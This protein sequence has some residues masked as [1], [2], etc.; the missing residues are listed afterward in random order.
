MSYKFNSYVD[1]DDLNQSKKELEY[2]DSIGYGSLNFDAQYKWAVVLNTIEELGLNNQ[3]CKCIEIGGSISPIPLIL[4]NKHKVIDVDLQHNL[5]WFPL[6][7]GKKFLK[8]SSIKYNENNITYIASDDKVMTKTLIA[9]HRYGRYVDTVK[10]VKHINK[11]NPYLSYLKLLDSN[12]IDFICDTSSRLHLIDKGEQIIKELYRV[13]KPGGYVIKVSDVAHPDSTDYD[14]IWHCDKIVNLYKGYGF[15]VW[16]GE[17][18]NVEPFY[19]DVKNFHHPMDHF[20]RG[21]QIKFKNTST[22][23]E[24]VCSKLPKAHLLCEYGD[25]DRGGMDILRARFLFRKA[26]VG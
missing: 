24:D 1:R 3:E 19:K 16:L 15:K 18:W 10:D 11:Y 14:D 4:S 23:C 22:A 8:G 21:H 7:K 20:Q 12:S 26:K 5:T 9:R 25:D 2:L 6:Q 17:D 13:L